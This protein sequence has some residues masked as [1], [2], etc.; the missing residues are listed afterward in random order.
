M[1]FVVIQ[2]RHKVPTLLFSRSDGLSLVL[3]F[4]NKK[5]ANNKNTKKYFH[6]Q[7]LIPKIK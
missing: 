2:R 1:A 6:K 7:T 5:H 3:L 4:K